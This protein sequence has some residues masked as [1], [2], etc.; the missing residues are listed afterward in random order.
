MEKLDR[1]NLAEA[2][3]RS[4]LFSQNLAKFILAF[5]PFHY[6]ENWRDANVGI[7]RNAFQKSAKTGVHLFIGNGLFVF[8]R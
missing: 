1:S 7:S 4:V 5:G 2:Q 6:L 3:V 8:I